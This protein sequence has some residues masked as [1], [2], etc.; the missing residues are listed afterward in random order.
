MIIL[1]RIE[2]QKEFVEKTSAI[3]DRLLNWQLDWIATHRKPAKKI[4]EQEW[5]N[6]YLVQLLIIYKNFI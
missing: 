6:F 5:M 1:E 3:L 2:K 4:I